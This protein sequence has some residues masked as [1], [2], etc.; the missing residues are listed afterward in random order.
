VLTIC[1]LFLL[2]SVASCFDGYGLGVCDDDRVPNASQYEIRVG[3]LRVLF[4]GFVFSLEMAC[5]LLWLCGVGVRLLLG[6]SLVRDFE[7]F[8]YNVVPQMIK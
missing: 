1:G 8:S 5:V 7:Y 4:G 6:P 2:G 3:V